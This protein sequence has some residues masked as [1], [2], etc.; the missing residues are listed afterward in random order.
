MDG[1][2][3]VYRVTAVMDSMPPQPVY[4]IFIAGILANLV[5][6]YFIGASSVELYRR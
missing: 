3:P 6:W 1:L 4:E 2:L 5:V